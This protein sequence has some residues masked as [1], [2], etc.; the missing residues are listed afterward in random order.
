MCIRWRRSINI[1]CVSWRRRRRGGGAFLG[2]ALARP[3]FVAR[4]CP[5]RA[6]APRVG[7]DGVR[8]LRKALRPAAARLGHG[9]AL[10]WRGNKQRRLSGRVVWMPIIHLT[11]LL[12]VRRGARDLVPGP[13]PGP[14]TARPRPG[15]CLSRSGGGAGG[16]L[17]P[18]H[19]PRRPLSSTAP[20]PSEASRERSAGAAWFTTP[21]PAALPLRSAPA[22]ED[23]HSVGLPTCGTLP[24]AS[25]V[26]CRE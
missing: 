11:A 16:G 2:A 4:G 8:P 25:R 15:P 21:P 9:Q 7:G 19:P 17:P 26:G 20:R 6:K 1:S 24:R 3:E 5:A 18:T 22:A 12:L 23:L 13:R 14:G 10:K